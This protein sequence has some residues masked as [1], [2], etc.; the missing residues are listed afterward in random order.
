MIMYYTIL[1]VYKFITTTVPDI[2]VS[3]LSACVKDFSNIRLKFCNTC[4]D[5]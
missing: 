2:I 1:L 4:P 3:K 5:K